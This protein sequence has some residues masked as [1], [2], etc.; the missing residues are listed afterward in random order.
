MNFLL[1]MLSTLLTTYTDKTYHVV[2]EV[3]MNVDSQ[4][5]RAVAD[6]F[7]Y[8]FQADAHNLFTWAYVGMDDPKPQKKENE[9]D[10]EAIK[11]R[12]KESHYDAKTRT[13]Y[14][15]ISIL[16]FDRPLKNDI[17][18]TGTY[19]DSI[20]GRKYCNRIDIDYSGSLLQ[21]ANAGFEIIPI[22][23]THTRV[24]IRLNV[25]FG[26]FFNGLVSMKFFQ[27]NIDWRIAVILNNCKEYAETG[28]V[29]NR[30]QAESLSRIQRI[31]SK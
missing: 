17:K 2:S 18:I 26:R 6:K 20:V 11:I 4:K 3:V 27:N 7:G 8:E 1:I 13:S 21:M 12:Y 16:L 19:S 9:P 24:R 5:A 10:R 25:Q 30:T 28:K 29:R 22:D 23:S 15:I 31:K 14:N